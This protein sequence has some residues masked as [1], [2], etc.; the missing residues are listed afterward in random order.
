MAD[1]EDLRELER[2]GIVGAQEMGHSIFEVAMKFGFHVRPFHECTVNIGNPVK[3]QI[4]DILAAGNRSCKE[5]DQR[6]LTRIINRP[7]IATDFNARSSINVT[8]QEPFNET[9]LIWASGAKGLLVY[10]C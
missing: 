1:Y 5:R 2:G 8:V 3:H 6:R 4:Y 9:S 7:Q 10:P